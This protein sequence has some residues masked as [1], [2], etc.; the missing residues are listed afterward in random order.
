MR[1]PTKPD[2]SSRNSG[3][4][5]ESVAKAMGAARASKQPQL[6]GKQT[7]GT[8]N[9]FSGV[10]SYNCTGVIAY[11]F[12]G[13]PRSAPVE[14]KARRSYIPPQPGLFDQAEE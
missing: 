14:R 2:R 3:S 7:R 9:G 5:G 13:I 1:R 12:D 11:V 6:V 4:R 10:K 8:A